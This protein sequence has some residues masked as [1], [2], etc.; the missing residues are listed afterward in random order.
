MSDV[1]DLQMRGGQQGFV[2]KFRRVLLTGL[3]AG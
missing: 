2:A 1:I 3:L